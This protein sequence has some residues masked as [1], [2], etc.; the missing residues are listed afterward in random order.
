[1]AFSDELYSLG[2]KYKEYE[3][4]GGSGGI[5][6]VLPHEE[7]VKAAII[8][9]F[10]K[11]LGYDTANPLEVMPEYTA[12]VP[13]KKGE[14]VDFAVMHKG[15]AIILIEC[16]KADADLQKHSGQLFRYFSTEK[17]KFALLTNGKEYRFY[18]D[19][20]EDNKMDIDHFLLA[21]ITQLNDT[22]ITDL[23]RFHKDSFQQEEL[24]E[25]AEKLKYLNL[26]K[27]KIKSD[28][29]NPEKDFVSTLFKRIKGPMVTDKRLPSYTELVR[30]AWTQLLT[31]NFNARIARATMPEIEQTP[32][33]V[34]EKKSIETTEE[35]LAFHKKVVN[36]L[37]HDTTVEHVTY[38]DAVS[39]FAILWEDNRRQPIAHLISESSRSFHGEKSIVLFP[40]NAESQER[41]ELKVAIKSIDEIKNY[42]DTLLATI[43]FYQK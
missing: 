11:I 14:K 36:L 41:E 8:R 33:P 38:R 3:E 13:G 21:D 12:D 34:I 2:K 43:Q 39:H 35:E 31:E 22:V 9:P 1:M 25:Y 18:T 24:L 10:I 16:K 37:K 20:D 19:L 30:N 4:A 5:M 27:D 23:K 6:K 28:F 32:T 42:K 7:A 40:I 26:L 17:A 29:E 15:D